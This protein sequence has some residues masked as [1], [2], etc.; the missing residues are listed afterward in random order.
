MFF[1]KFCIHQRWYLL[2]PKGKQMLIFEEQFHVAFIHTRKEQYVR[3]E[4]MEDFWNNE[5]DILVKTDLISRDLDIP[6]VTHVIN[7]DTP[8]SIEDYITDVGGQVDS[9]RKKE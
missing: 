3:N 8:D 6:S 7:F 9:Y 1:G 5:F 4:L 2:I